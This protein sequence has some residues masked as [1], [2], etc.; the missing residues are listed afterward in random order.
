MSQRYR[1]NERAGTSI[2]PKRVTGA[3][4][5]SSRGSFRPQ[6]PADRLFG[7]YS[8]VVVKLR[9][10]MQILDTDAEKRLPTVAINDLERSI[11]Q[12]VAAVRLGLPRDADTSSI[13]TPAYSRKLKLEL[14]DEE[15][16]ARVRKNRKSVQKD[17]DQ[18]FMER[19]KK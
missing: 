15:M 6:E 14:E 4:D 18:K 1:P 16:A 12:F 10:A 5:R 3:V 7:H 8:R 9:R 13:H 17:I 2:P 19:F 11:D